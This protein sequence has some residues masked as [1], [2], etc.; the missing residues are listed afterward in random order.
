MAKILFFDGY[1]SLCNNLI[2]KMIRW[3]K[4]AVLKFASLQGETA[5]KMLPPNRRERTDP[6][7]VIYLREG[8]I[9]E[10]STAILLSLR[11]IGGLWSLSSMFFIVPKV[12]RNL[13]YRF[14][15]NTRY[16]VFGKRDVCRLPLPE[17]RERLLP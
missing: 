8:E 16:Q 17:E 11:D 3:D 4:K 5:Q 1:C 7:T 13:I 12:L 2:D 9:Y 15:A 14:V 10:R 6:D